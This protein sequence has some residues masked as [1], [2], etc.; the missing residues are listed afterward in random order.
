VA[1]ACAREPYTG[2]GTPVDG[3]TLLHIATYFNEL[4]IAEWLL[5][6]G[7]VRTRDR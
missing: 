6:R 2:Q 7:M 3:T 5:V 4:E 1:P